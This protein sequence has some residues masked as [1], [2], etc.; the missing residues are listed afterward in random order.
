MEMEKF[1]RDTVVAVRPFTRQPDGEEVIIGSSETGVF[2]AVPSEAVELLEQLAAGKNVGEVSDLYRQRYGET[3]DL[4]DF[5]LLLETKG[6]VGPADGSSNGGATGTSAQPPRQVRYHFGNFPQPLARR[7]FSSPALAVYFLVMGLALAAMIRDPWLTPVPTDLFFPDHRA[8]SWA[9]LILAGYAAIFV[10]ELAHLVATLAVGVK[11]RM[12]ISHRL[13]YLVAETDLTGLWSVPKRQ[14]YLPLLAGLVVDATSTA[15]LVLLLFAWRREWLALSTFWMRLARAMV[16]SYLMGIVWQ[17]FL[18]V[19]TDL[20]F[21]I[22]TFL[23]CRN[24]LGDTE[25]FLRNQ[26]ARVVPR[27]GRENQSAIPANEQRVIRAYSLVWIAGRIWA[28]CVLLLVTV[29]VGIKYVRDLGR[30]FRA[31]YSANLS[32]FA[33]AAVVAA[34][35]IIPTIVGFV[36][37]IGGL[38]RRERT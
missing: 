20:Y 26:V 6:L 16:F 5:L 2:L 21:L 36:L 3:P 28:T 33:D 19:R 14:R 9:I 37:W 24:L 15:L 35:F 32:N 8:L 10:H 17:F 29:P 38:A 7:L 34:Y 4:E 31:G 11:S 1:T 23:N 30:A 12:G 22:A 25:E 18:F 27:M 13:W